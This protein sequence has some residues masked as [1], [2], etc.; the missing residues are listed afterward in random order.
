MVYKNQTRANN[1]LL[2][3]YFRLNNKMCLIFVNKLQ[4]LLFKIFILLTVN[5]MLKNINLQGQHKK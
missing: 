3:I 1:I 4:K 5:I 2:Y